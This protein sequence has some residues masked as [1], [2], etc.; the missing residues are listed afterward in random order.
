M[1]DHQKQLESVVKRCFLFLTKKWGFSEP[2]IKHDRWTSTFSYLLEDIGIEIEIDWR[3]LDVYLLVVRLKNNALPEG[4]YISEGTICRVHLV[5]LI[6]ELKWNVD[7]KLISLYKRTSKIKNPDELAS[8]I[9][10]F[11]TLLKEVIKLLL[12]NREAIFKKIKNK[13]C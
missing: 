12:E 10:L 2:K 11:S 1:N 3:D 5:N 13:N 9:E 4:Y 6:R 8:K 7:K